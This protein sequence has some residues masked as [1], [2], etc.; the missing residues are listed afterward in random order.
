VKVSIV[1]ISFNQCQFLK[2]CIDSVLSQR[3]NL[4][5][6]GV[7][8]EYILVDPGSSDGSRELIE[9]YGDE[10][11]KIFKKDMG[12]ADGLNKGFL[13]AT[14]NI[15]AYINADDY[16]SSNAFVKAVKV[17]ESND[18]DVFSGHGWIVDEHDHKSHRCLS[19]KFSLKQYALGNCVV[20]Q[21]STFFKKDAYIKSGGFN[22]ENRVSWDGELMVDMAIG[23]SKIIRANEF[24]SFFRVYSTSISGS[25]DFLEAARIE[26]KRVI[27]KMSINV[28]TS[29]KLV[30]LHRVFF[31]LLDPYY[32]ILRAIDGLQFGKRKI[33]S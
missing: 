24:L 4:A 32:F 14:G 3:D 6:I 18:C 17:F 31:R 28:T 25:G 16:F 12:P 11:F 21:Q 10:I 13:V 27:S 22:V 20:M 23:G 15:Y 26:H 30:L 1:T 8:L 7:E 19:H 5:A 2:Q 29:K 33:P 9:S